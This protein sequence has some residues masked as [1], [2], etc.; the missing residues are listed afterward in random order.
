MQPTFA[1][2]HCGAAIRYKQRML[3]LTN[4]VAS[5]AMQGMLDHGG[6][7]HGIHPELSSDENAECYK[8]YEVQYR[9]ALRQCGQYRL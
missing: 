1:D 5:E 2:K 7:I 8:L 4:E 9:T 3:R 6:P